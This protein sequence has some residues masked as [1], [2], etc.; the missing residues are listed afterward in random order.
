MVEN[1]EFSKQ[2]LECINKVRID[3]PAFA[4]YLE[5]NELPYIDGEGVICLPGKDPIQLDEGKAAV[6]LAHR[7]HSNFCYSTKTALRV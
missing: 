6:S 3:P 2:I 1:K 4:A 7:I 5:K